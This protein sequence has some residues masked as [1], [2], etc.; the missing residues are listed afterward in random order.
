[1]DH[2]FSGYAGFA[3]EGGGGEVEGEVAFAGVGGGGVA[4]VFGGI[5]DDFQV[6]YRQ[7]GFD[8]VTDKVGNTHKTH[9]FLMKEPLFLSRKTAAVKRIRRRMSLRGFNLVIY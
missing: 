3:G 7:G 2:A 8:L 5:I 4:V 1:M 6:G 9:Y